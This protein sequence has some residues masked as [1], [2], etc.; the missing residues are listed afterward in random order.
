[1]TKVISKIG[2]HGNLFLL[3]K[4]VPTEMSQLHIKMKVKEIF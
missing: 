4:K 2:T 3:F 1:M